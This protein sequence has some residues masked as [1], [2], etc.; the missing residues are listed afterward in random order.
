MHN[1]YYLRRHIIDYPDKAR[2]H[3]EELDTYK[4]I[5]REQK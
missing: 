1:S 4:V 2:K 5:E 3:L